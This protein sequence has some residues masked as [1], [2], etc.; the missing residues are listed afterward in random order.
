MKIY[1]RIN[2]A[3]ELS[4]KS[5]HIRTVPLWR[6]FSG[7]LFVTAH[8]PHDIVERLRETFLFC[9]ST[10]AIRSIARTISNTVRTCSIL[11]F[12]KDNSVEGIQNRENCNCNYKV[13]DSIYFVSNIRYYKDSIDYIS[14]EIE[15]YSINNKTH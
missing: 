8:I 2:K 15:N 5:A 11:F 4:I 6:T 1:E 14:E 12:K 13:Y 10:M 7:P 3:R 9:I